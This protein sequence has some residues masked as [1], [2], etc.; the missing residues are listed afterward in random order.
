MGRMRDRHDRDA[1]LHSAGMQY[2]FVVPNTYTEQHYGDY[3]ASRER[4]GLPPPDCLRR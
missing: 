1:Y 4:N 3:H 2:Y